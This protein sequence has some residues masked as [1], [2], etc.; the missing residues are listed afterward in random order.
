MYKFIKYFLSEWRNYTFFKWYWGRPE[1][2]ERKQ[3]LISKGEKFPKNRFCFALEGARI[4]YRHRD[5][6]SRRC[7]GDCESCKLKHC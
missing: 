4:R 3:E 5:R 7:N 2:A 1:I 6:F